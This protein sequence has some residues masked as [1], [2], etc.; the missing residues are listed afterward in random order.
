MVRMDVAVWTAVEAGNIVHPLHAEP[1]TAPASS[2]S[3]HVS[4]AT[5]APVPEVKVLCIMSGQE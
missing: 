4:G 1:A 5:V 2:G 3:L